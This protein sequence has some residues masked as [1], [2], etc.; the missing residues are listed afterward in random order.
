MNNHFKQLKECIIVKRP[1]EE[2]EQHFKKYTPG[3]VGRGSFLAGKLQTNF[4]G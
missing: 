1:V 2:I 3:W 4:S